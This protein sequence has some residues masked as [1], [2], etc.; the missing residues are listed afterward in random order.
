MSLAIQIENLSKTYPNGVCALKGVDLK[1]ERGDFFALLGP[2]GAGKST[3]LRIV[4]TMTRK[5]EGKVVVNGCDLDE[6]PNLY[7]MQLGI[8]PQEINLNVFE[9]VIDVLVFQAGYFGVAPKKAKEKATEVL[10]AMSLEDKARSRVIELSGG[11]KRRLMI[12]RSMIHDPRI[13]ILDEPTAGVDVEIRR[14][15]WKYIRRVNDE[16]VTV[17][18]T[19]H[20]LEEAEQLC[21]NLAIIDRGA[22]LR[23]SDVA[24]LL[25]SGWRKARIET[26]SLAGLA[27]GFF[28]EEEGVS[29][30]DEGTLQLD[31][32]SEGSL[33]RLLRR[34]I[35]Q[36]IG[37]RKVENESRKLEDVFLSLTGE[38]KEPSAK[39]GGG[40]LGESSFAGT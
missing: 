18:L 23:R 15:M 26:S 28:Q 21:R 38:K 40:S 35:E 1:V 25:A 12:A 13:L 32:V 17:L 31:G 10:R 36:G 24:S 37:I 5:T 7:K 2:N 34:L 9:K 27:P 16:G 20:Y 11:M 19:T 29:V 8:T 33:D 4:S 30:L 39:T 6:N 3:L 14:S 22:I